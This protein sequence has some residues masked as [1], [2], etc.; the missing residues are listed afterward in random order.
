MASRKW[1]QWISRLNDNA[2]TSIQPTATTPLWPLIVDLMDNLIS[3][4]GQIG[5]FFCVTEA[6]ESLQPCKHQGLP[7]ALEINT[8]RLTLNML[9]FFHHMKKFFVHNL[10]KAESVEAFSLFQLNWDTTIQVP[11]VCVILRSC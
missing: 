11:Q 2:K 1:P 8:Q 4:N 7:E 6:K 5:S 3:V 9:L 10:M